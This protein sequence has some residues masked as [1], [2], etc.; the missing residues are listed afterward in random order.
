M[1]GLV[2]VEFVLHGVNDI[3]HIVEAFF[4]VF[5][6]FVILLDKIVKALGGLD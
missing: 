5:R 2:N 3:H 4:V 6:F 1:S